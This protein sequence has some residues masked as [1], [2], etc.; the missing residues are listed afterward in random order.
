MYNPAR[1]TIVEKSNCTLNK[2]IINLKRD[3]RSPKDGLNNALLT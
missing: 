1:Q 3:E 2:I